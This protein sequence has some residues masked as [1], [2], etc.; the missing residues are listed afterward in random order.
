MRHLAGWKSFRK[1][2]SRPVTHYCTKTIGDA[3]SQ[4][5]DFFGKLNSLAKDYMKF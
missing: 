3:K 1:E 2:N 4:I 5:K